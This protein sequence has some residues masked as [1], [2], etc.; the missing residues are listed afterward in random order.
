MK[1]EIDE[2]EDFLF[3]KAYHILECNNNHMSVVDFKLE[4]IRKCMTS[5]GCTRAVINEWVQETVDAGYLTLIK[6]GYI[7]GEWIGLDGNA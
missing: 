6:D 3:E 5:P 2:I 4:M 1:I 7:R